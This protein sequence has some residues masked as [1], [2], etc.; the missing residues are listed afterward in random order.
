[1]KFLRRE[2]KRNVKYDGI[3]LDPPTFGRGTSGQ[4]F[5]IEQDFFS[6]L[7][8]CKSVLSSDPLFMIVTCHTPGF[9]PIVLDNIVKQVM[10]K[11]SFKFEESI[12]NGDKMPVPSG[13]C[14][15]WEPN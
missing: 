5:Q 10:R 11:G 8:L 12:L 7:D 13:S 4:L 15:I 6:L 2:V 9:T 3:I 1:M 14:L